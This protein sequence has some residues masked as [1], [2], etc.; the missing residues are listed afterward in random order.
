MKPGFDFG[1]VFAYNHFIAGI[2]KRRSRHAWMTGCQRSPSARRPL[3]STAVAGVL[4][5]ATISKTITVLVGNTSL[6]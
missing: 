1:T 3:L 4:S 2:P 6:R 5:V